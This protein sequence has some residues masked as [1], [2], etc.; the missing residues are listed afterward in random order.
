M[1]KRSWLSEFK[2]IHNGGLVVLN[3]AS[4]LRQIRIAAWSPERK[5]EVIDQGNQKGA[6]LVDLVEHEFF[7]D[8]DIS[9]WQV[10]MLNGELIYAVGLNSNDYSP[11]DDDVVESKQP[12]TTKNPKKNVQQGLTTLRSWC[13]KYGKLL[14]GSSNLDKSKSYLNLLTHLLEKDGYKIEI[15]YEDEPTMGYYLIP[16]N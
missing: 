5:R 11:F 8:Y 9:L 6:Y 4:K 12:S 14:I 15:A 3:L 1:K 7:D 16:T 10:P 13:G 2:A